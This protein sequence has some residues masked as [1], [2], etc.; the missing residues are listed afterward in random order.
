[1]KIYISVFFFFLISVF[2]ISAQNRWGIIGGANLSTS[3]AKDFGWRTGGYIGGLYD[4][5]LS[6]SWYIQPQLLYSY[7]ENSTK[8]NSHIDI[9]YSQH[10]LTLPVLASFKVPLSDAFSLRINVGPYIQYALF[11]RNG[12]SSIDMNGEVIPKKLGWWHAD[13]GDHFTYGLKGGLA[14]EHRHL[15]L[16]MDCKYSLK[17]SFLNYD[18]HGTTLSVGIGYKF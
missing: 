14:L 17:K 9:F 6:E 8:D 3:S 13:F 1:M 2:H 7:E 5:R 10:A 15:F 11:G 12:R 16:S 18:G 4:I